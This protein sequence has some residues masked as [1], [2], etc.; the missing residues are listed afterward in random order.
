M[1]NTTVNVFICSF[2]K[3]NILYQFN[4]KKMSGPFDQ[5]FLFTQE[6][7]SMGDVFTRG[8]AMGS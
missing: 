2:C 7:K 4:A 1:S 5:S 3:S 6:I 8:Y